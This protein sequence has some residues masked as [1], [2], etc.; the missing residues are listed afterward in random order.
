M[1]LRL[2][3]LCLPF[4]CKDLL[5][6]FHYM[7]RV[8][9]ATYLQQWTCPESYTVH[10]LSTLS[11]IYT[12]PWINCIWYLSSCWTSV[13]K[14]NNPQD[15]PP[16]LPLP[17]L[18]IYRNTYVSVEDNGHRIKWNFRLKQHHHRQQQQEK[19]NS[20]KG[21]EPNISAS[22][23]LSMIGNSFPEKVSTPLW[24]GSHYLE[25]LPYVDWKSSHRNSV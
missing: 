18:I 14:T 11:E 20:L 19:H 22:Q 16:I 15:P 24:E 10:A 25:M 12:V 23:D 2:V 21:L 13:D 7:H 9:I 3:R 6:P 8:I 17:G 4:K 1:I 5:L